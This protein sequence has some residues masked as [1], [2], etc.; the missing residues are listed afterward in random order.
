[1]HNIAASRQ[2]HRNTM[3]GKQSNAIAIAAVQAAHAAETHGR[4]WCY[5]RSVVRANEMNCPP[6]FGKVYA[7]QRYR[8]R[9]KVPAR[10]HWPGRRVIAGGRRSVSN[11]QHTTPWPRRRRSR[12]SRSILHPHYAPRSRAVLLSL[13]SDR[14]SFIVAHCSSLDITLSTAPRARLIT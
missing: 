10:A 6:S 14:H 13:L 11:V 9:S 12:S 2:G 1:M 5:S 7:A 4:G 8:A 3:A